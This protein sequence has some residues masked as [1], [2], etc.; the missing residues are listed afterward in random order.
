F[1][2]ASRPECHIR[3]TFA[4]L[5]LDGLHRPLNVNQ[6]FQ[7]VRKYLLD[8][9]ARIHAENRITMTTVPAPWPSSD[10]VEALVDK[11]SGHF[12]FVSTVIKFI[13]DKRFRPVERLNVILGIKNSVSASPFDTLDQFYHQ[14]ISDVPVDFRDQLLGILAVIMERSLILCVEQIE[15]LLELE[16][17]EVRLIL[18]RLHSVI[19]VPEKRQQASFSSSCLVSGFPQ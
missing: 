11:S 15:K 10:I 4:C 16:N 6:S 17:G 19:Y 1:F 14:I 18:R 2:I 12:V 9:F 3:E 8:Q 7:D 13:D 5:G